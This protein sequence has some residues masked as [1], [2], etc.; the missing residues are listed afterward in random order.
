MTQPSMPPTSGHS[1]T[2][3][4]LDH[5]ARPAGPGSHAPIHTSAEGLLAGRVSIPVKD[6]AMPAYRAAPDTPGPH[7]M[8]LVVQEIFGVHEHI[9]DVVRRLARQGYLAIAPA[10]YFRLGD[11]AQAG[12]I[13]EV[14]QRF[15]YQTPDAQVMADLDATVAWADAQHR[16]DAQRPLG[17][18]GF[19]WGGRIT[20]LYAAHQPRVA[21]AVAWYG[22]LEGKIS[23]ITPHHPTDVVTSLK[24]PVLGLYGGQD[25]GIPLDSVER[26]QAKLA[27]AGQGSQIHV[28]P[29]APHA[30]FADYRASHRPTEAQ[31]GWARLL[32]WFRRHGVR[33]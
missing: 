25:S 26:M 4:T 21:A 5:R 28:Y 15:V 14:M 33:P 7:P 20:W 16:A 30:F 3:A 18:T 24:A 10:L 9:E 8:V 6:G 32:D 23:D 27:H 31:D 2:P 22:R 13:D 19:C 11:P 1:S 12:S 29:D 17:V